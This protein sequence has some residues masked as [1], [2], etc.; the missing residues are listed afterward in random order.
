MK[1][2]AKKYLFDISQAISHIFEV[3]LSQIPSKEIFL[4]NLTVQRATER[5]LAIIGEA[6]HK[7]QKEGVHLQ[8][9]DS[10]INRRNTLV[11]QYDSFNPRNIWDLIHHD[12]PPLKQEVDQLM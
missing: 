5:E 6:C 2:T 8:H 12:L 10:M 1:K 3:H 4:K 9:G 7:L 11:H